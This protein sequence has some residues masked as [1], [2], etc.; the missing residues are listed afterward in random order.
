MFQRFTRLTFR[1]PCLRLGNF[2][3]LSLRVVEKSL[4]WSTF[5][6][7]LHYGPLETAPLECFDP[8]RAATA[9]LLTVE[10]VLVCT[11]FVFT[12][13]PDLENTLLCTST[14]LLFF[15]TQSALIF[16]RHTTL[17]SR[18]PQHTVQP[19][20][21]GAARRGPREN[22]VA[23]SA[24]QHTAVRGQFAIRQLQHAPNAQPI[25]QV[26]NAQPTSKFP[27]GRPANALPSAFGANDQRSG[28]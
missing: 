11:V 15:T 10:S 18:A 22:R 20:R 24:L 17:A 4:N 7:A 27:L 19:G 14:N 26:P 28:A 16:D 9:L 1:A 3:T 13:V 6:A 2:R 8:P 23:D 5:C 25:G 12:F 21:R